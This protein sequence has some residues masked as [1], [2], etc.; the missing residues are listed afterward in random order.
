MRKANQVLTRARTVNSFLAIFILGIVIAGHA[1]AQNSVGL[2]ILCDG[3]ARNSHITI[4]DRY[5]GQCP[6][7]LELP[8]GAINLRAVKEVDSFQ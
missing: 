4:N 2:R 6:M 8:A 7:D 1:A 5:M 3:E